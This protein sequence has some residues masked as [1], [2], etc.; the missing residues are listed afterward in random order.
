MLIFATRRGFAKSWIDP[1]TP[2]LTQKHLYVHKIVNSLIN[3]T[4]LSPLAL[5]FL[6]EQDLH[7]WVKNCLC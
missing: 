6:F 4:Q 2:S 5:R 3:R 7:V 1:T